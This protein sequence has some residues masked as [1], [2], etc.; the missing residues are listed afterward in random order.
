MT[1]RMYWSSGATMTSFSLERIRR[2]VSSF[3]EGARARTAVQSVG[4]QRRRVSGSG[5]A[6]DTHCLI[7]VPDHRCRLFRQL[8]NQRS[9]DQRLVV[10][11]RRAD[12]NAV[13]RQDDDALDALLALHPLDR[14]LHL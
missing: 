4:P 9:V 1:I 11:E 2:N 5:A 6:S 7:K 3:C 14:V 8:R 10:V 12:R 13:V